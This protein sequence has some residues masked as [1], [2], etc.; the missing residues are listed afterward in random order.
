MGLDDFLYGEFEASDLFSQVGNDALEGSGD[1]LGRAFFKTI[2]FASPRLAE[3]VTAVEKISQ[4][5][6][7]RPG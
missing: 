7:F 6:F 5:T 3:L 2:F 4:G 1:G